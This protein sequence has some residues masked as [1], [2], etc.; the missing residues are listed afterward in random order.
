MDASET[1]KYPPTYNACKE[2]VMLKNS[3]GLVVSEY[4]YLK[5]YAPYSTD[6]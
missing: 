5:E 1:P 2:L 3:R 4:K 6:F